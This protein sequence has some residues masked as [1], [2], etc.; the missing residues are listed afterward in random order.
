M[1]PLLAVIAILWLC[2]SPPARSE[3]AY[4]VLCG[5]HQP[6]DTCVYDGDTFW[7]RGTAYR[8]EDLDTPEKKSPGCTSEGILASDATRRLI[9]LLNAGEFTLVRR[10]P[11]DIDRYGRRLRTVEIAGMSIAATMIAEGIARPWTGK[12]QPWCD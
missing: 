7:L 11:R 12:R 6:H 10:G 9:E 2:I 5:Y 3:S 8:I 1:R 4:F